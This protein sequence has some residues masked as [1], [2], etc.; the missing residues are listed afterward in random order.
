MALRH[1]FPRM[2]DADLGADERKV[3]P[4]L[5]SL[6][7]MLFRLGE[8]VDSL[9]A[10]VKK[11]RL[12]SIDAAPGAGKSVNFPAG[13]IRGGFGMVV[14]VVP[15]AQLSKTL[16][17]YVPTVQKGIAFAHVADYSFDEDFPTEGLVITHA[18][19]LIAYQAT[20]RARC[21]NRR[22]F[23][24][25]LDEVHE[26]DAGMAVLRELKTLSPGVTHYVQATATAGC[27]D[28][29]SPFRPL[30]T[31]APNREFTF[32]VTDPT[33]WKVADKGVPWSMSNLV[34]DFLVFVDDDDHAR[35]ISDTFG[36]AGV[37][38]HRFTVKTPP[39]EF[40]RRKSAIEEEHRRRGPIQAFLCD[41]SYRSGQTFLSLARIIDLGKVKELKLGAGGMPTISFRDMTM[42]ESL[43]AR[44]RGSRIPGKACDYWR[45]SG[46]LKTIAY[47][48]TGFEA[49]SAC[50]FFRMLGF[51]PPSY[52]E[53][54]PTYQGKVPEHL[55]SIMTGFEPVRR[56]YK[57]PM[58]EWPGNP[59]VEVEVEVLPPKSVFSTPTSSRP[60]SFVSAGVPDVTDGLPG[61]VSP[62]SE[63]SADESIGRQESIESLFGFGDD[64]HD[65][66]RRKFDPDAVQSALSRV[67][68]KHS[69][70]ARVVR[71]G[72]YYSVAR[73]VAAGPSVIFPRGFD[74]FWR[75]VSGLDPE[76]YALSLFGDQ[77]WQVVKLLLDTYNAAVALSVA[78][79]SI[80][81]TASDV[82]DSGR[83]D[84]DTVARW[85][86]MVR[87]SY[88]RAGVR[89]ASAF[90][91]LVPCAGARNL[92]LLDPLTRVEQKLAMDL[93]SR[94]GEYVDVGGTS[95]AG[96][97]QRGYEDMLLQDARP[98]VGDMSGEYSV[99]WTPRNIRE[100]IAYRLLGAPPTASVVFEAPVADVAKRG[101]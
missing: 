8:D 18:N 58:V 2:R 54:A 27:G 65:R 43:Q 47:M 97:G 74:E 38:C 3:I 56:Y 35:V 10:Q 26:S 99:N 24:L 63:I 68:T 23:C 83:Y 91:F 37:T 87:D 62:V 88:V 46:D 12:V 64:Y 34:G 31:K 40:A 9:A 25:Y 60:V 50:V 52:L 76:E 20:W 53:S 55:L 75:A 28:A 80:I 100:K 29:S 6:Q 81:S 78:A 70:S 42:A 49:D 30:E 90:K 17:D 48:L 45:P 11:M 44:A 14:H 89:M 59:P 22:E 94:L 41:T 5:G 1:G 96:L 95:S 51:S 69:P 61:T 13:L 84:P 101:W 71:Q 82:L 93:L 16:A 7:T 39:E 33:K 67:M 77:K 92:L 32:G 86:A 57:G 15:A 85:V 36:K 72:E 19:A 4:R 66:D 21:D 98:V 73:A 79:S